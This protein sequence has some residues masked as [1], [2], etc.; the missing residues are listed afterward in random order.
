MTRQTNKKPWRYNERGIFHLP[1]IC[2]RRTRWEGP[3]KW[4]L[5]NAT[6]GTLDP[7]L[8]ITIPESQISGSRPHF[9]PQNPGIERPSIPGLPDWKQSSLTLYIQLAYVG[10]LIVCRKWHGWTDP[11]FGQRCTAG[12]VKI[13]RPTEVRIA[14]AICQTR[15][16]LSNRR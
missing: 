9:Q 7:W 16:Y 4:S 13:V 12:R 15:G 8:W 11:E 2:T 14:S 10:P 1:R 3:W 6:L 5:I